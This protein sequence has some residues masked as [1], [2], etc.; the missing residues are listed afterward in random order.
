M[1][2]PL[3]LCPPPPAPSHARPLTSPPS[4][5]CTH[6]RHADALT[7]RV[8]VELTEFTIVGSWK[9]KFPL[10][11][12]LIIFFYLFPQLD[13]VPMSQVGGILLIQ[14]QLVRVSVHRSLRSLSEL[15]VDGVEEKRGRATPGGW[16]G[17]GAASPTHPQHVESWRLTATAKLAGSRCVGGY[18]FG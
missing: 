16:G 5:P 11:M 4:D 10:I 9:G 15:L 1:A 8:G 14:Q 6:S 7:T 12:R 13:Q 17:G 3:P 2:K 18:L